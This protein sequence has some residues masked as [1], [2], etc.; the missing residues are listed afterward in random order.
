MT[1]ADLAKKVSDECGVDRNTVMLTIDKVLDSI[2]ESVVNGEE[3]FLRGFGTFG[4]K[5][6]AEKIGQN[7]PKG[8][9]IVIPAHD[10]PSFKPAKCFKN[11]VAKK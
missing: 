5:H 6:R 11:D 1:K 8:T 2:R 10:I 7:M 3:V 9:S 4:V